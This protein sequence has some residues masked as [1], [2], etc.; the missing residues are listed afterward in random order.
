MP[1]HG[2]WSRCGEGCRSDSLGRGKAIRP[3]Q[4]LPFEHTEPV[5]QLRVA[6]F[7][8]FYDVAKEPTGQDADEPRKPEGVVTI[9]AVRRKPG[10]KT[11]K[12]IL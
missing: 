9:R 7:R 4:Q 11:I 3:G 5:W 6:E 10:H 1:R 12:D 8:V 2:S